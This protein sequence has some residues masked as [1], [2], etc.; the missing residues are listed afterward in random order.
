MHNLME[1]EDGTFAYGGRAPAWHSLGRVQSTAETMEELVQAAGINWRYE[2]VDLFWERETLDETHHLLLPTKQLVT[3]DG[4]KSLDCIVSKDYEFYQPYEHA[5]AIDELLTSA[6][7]QAELNWKPETALALGKGE[8]TIY[9]V[10]LG[11]WSVGSD[12]VQDYLLFTDTVD[13]K[14]ALQIAIV[15]L[16][17][18]CQNTLNIGLRTAK[19]KLSLNHVK[20]HRDN[21]KE[22]IRVILESQTR[23]REALQE[24]STLK[25]KKDSFQKYVNELFPL[26]KEEDDNHSVKL[27]RKMGLLQTSAEGNYRVMIEE[28]KMPRTAWTAFNAV[29]ETIEHSGKF[30][31]RIGTQRSLLTGQG[32]VIAKINQAFDLVK[33]LC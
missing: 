2:L 20:G 10:S 14:H 15:N 24:L 21:T 32:P 12:E 25:M 27:V 23:V 9:C 13:G 3:I 22:A 17:V 28:Q 19:V 4:R 5:M 18:V 16:R 26:P 1:N 11:N 7:A 31:G 33:T 8:T 6:K 29:Q 30:L